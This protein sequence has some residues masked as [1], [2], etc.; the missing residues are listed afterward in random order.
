MAKLEGVKT[1][2]MINGEITKVEYNGVKYSKVDG[3]AKVGDLILATKNIGHTSKNKFYEINDEGP[4]GLRFHDD[5]SDIC[6]VSWTPSTT[7]K[8]EAPEFKVGD[9]V[10]AIKSN[11]GHVGKIFVVSKVYDKPVPYNGIIYTFEA[12]PLGESNGLTARS[13]GERS[14]LA[15]EKEVAAAKAEIEAKES[16]RKIEEKWARIGR[17]PGEFKEGDIVCVKNPCGANLDRGQ[18]V[19]VTRDSYS[20]GSVVVTHKRYRVSVSELITPVEA[21]FDR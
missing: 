6:A 8:R 11:S 5:N 12:K 7:F 17:N 10:K 21:R 9:C 13:N 19:E 15:T 18:L 3:E 1:L 16:Q 20:S 14:V 2:D 4:Y